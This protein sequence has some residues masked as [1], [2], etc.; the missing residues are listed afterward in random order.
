MHRIDSVDKSL[1]E[2]GFAAKPEEPRGNRRLFEARTKDATVQNGSDTKTFRGGIILMT[3]E[4][5]KKI[6][7]RWKTEG[8]Y[9]FVATV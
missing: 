7:E 3:E 5:T 9:P 8:R 4:K 1:R 6:R 2:N